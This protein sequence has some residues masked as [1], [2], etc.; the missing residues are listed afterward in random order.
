M[1][2]SA[3]T[4]LG[5]MLVLV[6]AG[7]T[8]L[9]HGIGGRGG[10]G[11]GRG[12][13]GGGFHGGGGGGGGGF[14]G[15][16]GGGGNFGGARPNVGSAPSF[17]RP[18]TPS[19]PTAPSVRPASP[20]PN[21]GSRP[22]VGGANVG[23][24]PNIGGG[25]IGG[26]NIGGVNRPETRPNL[27]GGNAIGNLP[28]TRPATGIGSG[29]GIGT[30][31]GI[32]ESG[33]GNRPGVSQGIGNRPNAG[34]GIANRPSTLPGRLPG[35]GA[36]GP[37]GSQL[38]NQGA[39]IQDRMQNASLEDRRTNLGDRMSNGRE[40]WQQHFQG[41]QN[42]RQDWRDNNRE[43]W[44]NWTDHKLD[45]YGDWYHG[46]WHPGASWCY[47]WD[48]Y[49]AAAAIGMT[50]WA[51]NRIGYGWGYYSYSNPYYSSGVGY[52]YSQPLVVYADNSV[53]TTS[54]TNPASP[55]SSVAQPQPTDEGMAAFDEARAAFQQG[56][57]AGALSR[58]DVTLKTMPRDTVVHEFRSL[59]LFALKKYPESSAAIYA[60]LS[61]GPGWDWTTMISLYPSAETYTNQIR[62]LE[63]FV[64][65]N[66]KSPDGHFLLAYHYQTMGHEDAA[67]KHF[68]DALALLPDDKLLKQLVAM[69]A[70][71]E[72]TPK[73]ETTTPPP[74]V[75]SEKSLKSEQ[76]IGNWA[77]SSGDSSFELSLSE[78]G[79]F[80]WTFSKGKRQQSVKGAF[81]VD[82]NN[83]ALETDDGSGTMLAEVTVIDP[84]TFQF[85][86]VGDAPKEAGLQFKKK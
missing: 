9:A 28:S 83:L 68:Q 44:Q 40:D 10:G 16:G 53:T 19:H 82:Q 39:R 17:S 64:K 46:G 76:L 54:V 5:V 65:A 81:A 60:V 38:P 80:Q 48:N 66:A 75:G 30:R 42:G 61:A 25:N 73:P 50:A 58:L 3:R 18:A 8:E 21:L 11:G 29:Q 22:N 23:N 77:A 12:G 43:D 1:K 13:G 6:I 67:A 15:G 32:G 51:V 55:P 41:M 86:M 69:T 74:A 24:R 79:S 37:L 52:D 45:H 7:W 56:D 33:I 71:P 31:P 62:D 26:G 27:G 35:L 85:K 84:K 20:G 2:T 14:H 78:N 4:W 70:P 59:V 72:K 47:M 57:Y 49:P 36:D 63:A 34:S